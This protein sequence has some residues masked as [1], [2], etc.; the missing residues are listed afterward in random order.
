MPLT[1]N[2]YKNDIEI[3]KAISALQLDVDKFWFAI[4]F[5]WDYVDGECWQTS[6]RGDYP[7]NEVNKLLQ[8]IAQ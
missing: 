3:K 7:A 5:I 8:A 1:Y 4:L 6:E 2:D